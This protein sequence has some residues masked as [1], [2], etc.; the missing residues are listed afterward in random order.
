MAPHALKRHLA[1][2]K[3]SRATTRATGR[4]SAIL[5]RSKVILQAEAAGVQ[6]PAGNL[7]EPLV[8]VLAG[9]GRIR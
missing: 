7:V 6:S 2:P 3:S 4:R 1:F 9:D 5:G 8:A